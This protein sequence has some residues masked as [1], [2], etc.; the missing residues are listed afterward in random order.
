MPGP[1]GEW[2]L[3]QKLERESLNARF[4]P[5]KE[6]PYLI[7]ITDQLLIR[8]PLATPFYANRQQD[9]FN[10]TIKDESLVMESPEYSD[11]LHVEVGSND[12]IL[13]SSDGLSEAVFHPLS[14]FGKSKEIQ[15]MQD[16]LT[17]APYQ[18]SDETVSREYLK[19]GSMLTSR[20]GNKPEDKRK[21]YLDTL[22]GELYLVLLESLNSRV[23]HIK[24]VNR[25]EILGHDYQKS[26]PQ[27][28]L[29]R[30]RVP[31]GVRQKDVVG[32]WKEKSGWI[33]P[34][35][36]IKLEVHADRM[37]ITEAGRER[38]LKWKLNALGT[39]IIFPALDLYDPDREW[40]IK[41][42]DHEILVIEKANGNL[43][44]LEE[45]R[46]LKQHNSGD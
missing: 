5:Q 3:H 36:W 18:L 15:R 34:N 6:A 9:T 41:H 8:T 10:I 20:V 45:R 42:L 27:V 22:G 1:H 46:L 7:S 35:Q 44:E 40:N 38:M 31:D 33:D 16:L 12:L 17:T 25:L 24:A 4:N 28:T 13:K 39:K 2:V 30:M 26:D 14:I 37:V 19:E 43:E 23:I 11:T 29:F 32:L 21:Y